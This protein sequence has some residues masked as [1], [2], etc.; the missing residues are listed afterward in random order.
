MGEETHHNNGA[1][2]LIELHLTTN[3]LRP[4]TRMPSKFASDRLFVM[5]AT[6]CSPSVFC[7]D[8]PAEAF[9]PVPAIIVAVPR[10]G[11]ASQ[12]DDKDAF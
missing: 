11:F 12:E 10:T 3:D 8:G 6:F 5:V 2:H 1:P 7:S 4:R 9:V